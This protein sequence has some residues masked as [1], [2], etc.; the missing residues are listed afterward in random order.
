MILTAWRLSD[1]EYW[2]STRVWILLDQTLRGGFKI[3]IPKNTGAILWC[4]TLEK[5]KS[6]LKNGSGHINYSRFASRDS[7]A[8]FDQAAVDEYLGADISANHLVVQGTMEPE[9]VAQLVE[10]YPELTSVSLSKLT[11]AER[12]RWFSGEG[13]PQYGPLTRLCLAL[14][15]NGAGSGQVAI[16]LGNW[17]D[18]SGQFMTTFHR[19]GIDEMGTIINSV[20]SFYQFAELIRQ[21]PIGV[22]LVLRLREPVPYTDRLVEYCEAIAPH[23]TTIEIDTARTISTNDAIGVSF[24]SGLVF[25]IVSSA[26]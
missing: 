9:V 7:V 11:S 3:G 22:N 5:L 10:R 23:V 4:E 1:P 19:N 24:L 18:D 17:A 12:E 8:V 6:A 25:T 16:D 14:K 2:G 20:D 13:P 15:K 26:Y 21:V